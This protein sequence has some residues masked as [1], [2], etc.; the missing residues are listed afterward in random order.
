[1]KRRDFL[2][3]SGVGTGALLLPGVAGTAP[4]YSQQEIKD[5]NVLV[6]MLR[7]KLREHSHADIFTAE[8]LVLFLKHSL[9]EFNATP[10]FTAVLMMNCARPD[11]GQQGQRDIDCCQQV[12]Q[13]ALLQALASRDLIERGWVFPRV[14]GGFQ[15]P[16]VSKMMER[17]DWGWVYRQWAHENRLLKKWIWPG[18]GRALR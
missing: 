13:G 3:A 15:P 4:K 1:M 6:K 17:P 11:K 9:T 16:S 14:D 5:L 7:K 12:V 8:Q 2:I 10:P 18:E